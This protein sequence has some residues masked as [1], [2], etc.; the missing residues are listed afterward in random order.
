MG[1]PGT[2]HSSN[3]QYVILGIADRQQA[4]CRK[5]ISVS[6]PCLGASAAAAPATIM[7]K[8]MTMMMRRRRRRR[9]MIMMM[10]HINA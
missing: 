8:N 3:L 4:E 10:M 1:H 2:Q 7:T 5:L 9:R 6:D